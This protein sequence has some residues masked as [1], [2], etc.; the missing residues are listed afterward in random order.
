MKELRDTVDQMN[1]SDYKERFRAEYEQTKIRYVKLASFINRIEAAHEV[2]S[3]FYMMN[4]GITFEEPKHDCPL[5]LLK[6]QLKVMDEY[7]KVLEIR[8][9]IENIRLSD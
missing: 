1:S 3:D 7:L 2:N 4:S 9:T 6:R 5:S 8:A